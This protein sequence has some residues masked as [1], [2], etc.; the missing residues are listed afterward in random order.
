MR[1][2]N[3]RGGCGSSREQ[4]IAQYNLPEGQLTCLVRLASRYRKWL[5]IRSTGGTDT[6]VDVPKPKLTRPLVVPLRPS[7]VPVGVER[8]RIRLREK[9]GKQGRG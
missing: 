3:K 7:Q 5:S 4:R 2:R 8:R 9:K 6:R 1:T